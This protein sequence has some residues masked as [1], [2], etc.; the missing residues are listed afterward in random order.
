MQKQAESQFESIKTLEFNE[1]NGYGFLLGLVQS[2]PEMQMDMA[3][4]VFDQ[5][6]KYHSDNTV[7]YRGWKSNDKHRTMGM[8]IK[9]TRFVL[10]GHKMWCK[11]IEYD[12]LRM[13]ADFDKVF[14]LVEGKSAPEV[15]L[16]SVFDGK[17]DP[18]SFSRLCCGER[19][20]STYFDVRYYPGVGTIHFFPKKKDAVDR[21]NR[22]VG[23]RRGW[24]PPPTEPVSDAFWLQ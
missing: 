16:V 11:S 8:R 20:S 5:I 21:L 24:L 10:P 19:L 17:Q 2:Q 12:S 22:I 7:Y 3:C 13:L 23:R 18:T 15:S 14:A 4:D 9:M 1:S 6:T